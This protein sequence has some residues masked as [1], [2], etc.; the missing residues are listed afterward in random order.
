MSNQGAS[1]WIEISKLVLNTIVLPIAVAVVTYLV[2]D[3]L[4]EWRKRRAYSRLGVAILDSLLE[5]LRTGLGIL[6]PLLLSASTPGRSPTSMPEL[7]HGSWAGMSTIPDEVLLRVIEASK[8]VQTPSFH[9][10]DARIHCKNYFEHIRRNYEAARDRAGRSADWRE[11]IL[12]A[13]SPDGG[14]DVQAVRGVIG[15]LE[16]ARKLLDQNANARFPK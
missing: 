4:G 13:L 1:N 14:A 6:Q 2:V 15:M 10:R 9:P 11:P 3:R 12:Q 16:L 5:E 8:D 7:P